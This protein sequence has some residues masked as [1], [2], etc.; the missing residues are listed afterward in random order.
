M[1]SMRSYVVDQSRG[2]VIQ[3]RNIRTQEMVSR[4]PAEARAHDEAQAR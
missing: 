3:H 1:V 2:D 4:T